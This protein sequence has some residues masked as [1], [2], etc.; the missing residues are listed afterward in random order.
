LGGR[1]RGDAPKRP[2]SRALIV[3][4]TSAW[5]EFLRK[6]G[7]AAHLRLRRAIEGREPVAV[8]EIVV[9]EV[10]AGARTPAEVE[11]L[12][13]LLRNF[14]LLRLKG[15]AGYEEAAALSRACR[16]AGEP[17]GS[18]TDALIAVPAIRVGVPV[19]HCDADFDKLVR[20]T[21]LEAVEL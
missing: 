3:V 15:L 17:I 1:P 6:T 9:G 12:G 19:L 14:T 8:T 20:H 11:T 5:V 21:A 16:A 4:D 7:S 2:D 18:I 10:L 13:A